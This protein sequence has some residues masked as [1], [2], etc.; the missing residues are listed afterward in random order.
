M[1]NSLFVYPAQCNFSGYKYPLEW[2][3]K[4]KLGHLD[5]IKRVNNFHIEES[6]VADALT[7]WS[8]MKDKD[9]STQ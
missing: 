2:I 7:N 6:N 9:G 8:K 3:P 5:G 1:N 4:I